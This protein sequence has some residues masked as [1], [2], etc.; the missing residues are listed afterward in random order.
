MLEA[1]TEATEPMRDLRVIH[2]H[3]SPP[4]RDPIR[5]LHIPARIGQTTPMG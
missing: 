3:I 1:A 2:I 4:R 5:A